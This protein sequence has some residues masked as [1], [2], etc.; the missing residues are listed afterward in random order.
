MANILLLEPNQ[1][2][3]SQVASY[4]AEQGHQV[5]LAHDAQS[6]INQTDQTTPDIVIIE[7]LLASHSGIEFLYEFRSYSEWRNVPVMIFSRITRTELATT[8]KMLASLGVTAYL[9][10]P[11]TTLKRLNNRLLASLATQSA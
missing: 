3:A 2:L 6:A 4:L 11:S 9:Y 10:K 8:D 7:V 5:R 1:L